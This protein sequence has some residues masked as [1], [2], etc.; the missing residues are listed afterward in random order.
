LASF[1]R[2]FKLNGWHLPDKF[3]KV[4]AFNLLASALHHYWS[5]EGLFY[6]HHFF[7]FLN[8]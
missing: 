7:F 1:D 6:Q 2:A 4:V 5:L 3:G 8:S